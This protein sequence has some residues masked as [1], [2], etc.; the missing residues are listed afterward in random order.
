MAQFLEQ[1]EGL[2]MDAARGLRPGGKGMHAAHALLVQD[3]F[4]E[5]GAGGVSGAEDENVHG[6]A[7]KVAL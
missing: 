7:R 3:G 4:E 2:G 5:D 1:L 6:V